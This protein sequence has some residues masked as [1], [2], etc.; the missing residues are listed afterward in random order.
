MGPS[1]GAPAF[2]QVHPPPPGLLQ[3]PVP[4]H[5]PRD[6]VKWMVS[7]STHV[8]G[9]HKPPRPGLLSPFFPMFLESP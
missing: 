9:C 5:T 2:R 8:T 6:R 3:T 1:V 7:P 4:L